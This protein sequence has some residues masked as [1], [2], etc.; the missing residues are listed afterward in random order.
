MLLNSLLQMWAVMFKVGFSGSRP[1]EPEETLTVRPV[2]A[3]HRCCDWHDTVSI[4][5]A[6]LQYRCS[7]YVC[8]CIESPSW[9]EQ[10]STRPSRDNKHPFPASSADDTIT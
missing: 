1:E 7:S 6:A 3:P 10:R 9:N 8:T 2:K 5:S 4:L